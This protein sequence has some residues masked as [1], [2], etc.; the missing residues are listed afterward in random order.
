LHRCLIPNA[1]RVR[2]FT[3]T[4]EEP[5]NLKKGTI[6]L[7]QALQRIAGGD[8][9]HINAGAI[10]AAK[11]RD[12]MAQFDAATGGISAINPDDGGPAYPQ[13]DVDMY[14][15][16]RTTGGMS[17][18]D[19]FAAQAPEIPSWFKYENPE[20]A[21]AMPRADK[22]LSPAHYQQLQGLGDY[23]EDDQ[24]DPEV[25]AYRDRTRAANRAHNSWSMRGKA[26]ELAAWRWFYADAMLDERDGGRI[27]S[28]RDASMRAALVQLRDRI[29]NDQGVG[30]VDID[31]LLR[32][33]G[34]ERE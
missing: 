33:L 11:A 1:R 4:D 7:F 26:R 3:T 13:H 22:E 20:P 12:A 17:V 2:A 29:M 6:Q 23:L 30:V 15:I 16:H 10:A 24:V 28:S 34:D 31:G 8:V 32:Q 5:M 27:D 9:K 21:P 14:G 25:V 19:A 18:R